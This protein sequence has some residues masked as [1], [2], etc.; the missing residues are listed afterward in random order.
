MNPSQIRI[1]RAAVMAVAMLDGCASQRSADASPPAAVV[2]PPA[3]AR[4]ADI[5]SIVD[6]A[7]RDAGARLNV[8]PSAIETV[9]A[10]AVTW[11]DGSLGCPVEGM[12]YTQAL[13]PG[14]R[15]TLRAAGRQLDYHAAANGHAV[16]CP[17]ERAIE[18]IQDQPT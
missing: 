7:I 17:P 11:S 13:V 9:S 16:L 18:P 3:Q 2:E 5:R 14:Y 8:D 15:V 12:Q 10:V 1:C 6:A 4:P